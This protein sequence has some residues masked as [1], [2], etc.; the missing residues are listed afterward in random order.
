[1]EFSRQKYWSGL[2]CPP[3]GDLP[4]PGIESVVSSVLLIGSFAKCL[5]SYMQKCM[6]YYYIAGLTP[7]SPLP[8]PF[9]NHEGSW[10][11]KKKTL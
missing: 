6:K 2:P 11:P 3:P 9:M 4:D 10:K 8:S 5:F 7:T 1:M